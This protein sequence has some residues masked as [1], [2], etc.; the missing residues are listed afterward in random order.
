MIH[1]GPLCSSR[2]QDPESFL[3]LTFIICVNGI[4][5]SRSS[6]ESVR[7]RSPGLQA[8]WRRSP[9]RSV[10]APTSAL[11]AARPGGRG[12]GY[13]K[14]GVAAVR[15]RFFSAGMSI[16]RLT[17]DWVMKRPARALLRN[18]AERRERA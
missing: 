17:F 18:F 8:G 1:D 7:S 15:P 12:Y 9:S 2:V 14:G 10:V 6:R 3:A 13:E 16:R 5:P 11:R 4:F